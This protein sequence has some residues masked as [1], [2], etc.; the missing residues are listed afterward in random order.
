MKQ[1]RLAALFC[2]PLFGSLGCDAQPKTVMPG[3]EEIQPMP[4][5]VVPMTVPEPPDIER[6]SMERATSGEDG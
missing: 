6:L 4:T 3:P 5:N 2:V 1:L